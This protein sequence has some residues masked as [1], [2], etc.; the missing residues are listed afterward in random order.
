[1][2]RV[3]LAGTPKKKAGKAAAKSA[4]PSNFLPVIHLLIMVGAA[5]AG[6]LWYSQ[7]T[8]KSTDLAQQITVKEAELKKLND[9]V[10][11]D[12]IYEARKA[13][14]EKRIKT[15]DDLKKSQVSPVVMLDRLVDSVDRT[16]FVWL[17]TFTQSNSSISMVG[18]A[19]NLEALAGFYANLQD[20]GY[21]HNINVN[22]F[23]D[24]RAGNVAFTLTS[25]FAPPA[26]PKPA[27]KGAN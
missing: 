25:D 24:S 13:E 1:M 14:L 27:V 21:F 5:V 3:N 2:I 20:T 10:A 8:T 9:V 4:G 16:K 19:T 26:A 12:K 23:E 11:Q 17:S 6:Y 7:L 22:R 18:V 15:I